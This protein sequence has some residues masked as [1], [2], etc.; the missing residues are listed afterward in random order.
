[1]GTELYTQ[2]MSSP[3]FSHDFRRTEFLKI[4]YQNL[5]TKF[6]DFA[7]LENCQLLPLYLSDHSN[8]LILANN[9][10]RRAIIY[11]L[12]D[13]TATRTKFINE[14]QWFSSM[15]YVESLVSGI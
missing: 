12:R 3:C 10:D 9:Q 6:H 7:D 11:N 2:L 13:N 14:I 8:T 5:R 15:V 4:S 1:M